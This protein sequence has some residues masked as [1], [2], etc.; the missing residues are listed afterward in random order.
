MA[1]KETTTAPAGRFDRSKN[2]AQSASWEL[3]ALLDLLLEGLPPNGCAQ[4][5]ETYCQG[6][7][8]RGLVLRM[9]SLASVLMSFADGETDDSDLLEEKVFGRALGEEAEVSH[10]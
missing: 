8:T 5:E 9:K 4:T 7:R 1:T 10:G 2:A 6:L 3:D